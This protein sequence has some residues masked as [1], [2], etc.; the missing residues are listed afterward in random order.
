MEQVAGVFFYSTPVTHPTPLFEAVSRRTYWIAIA[1]LTLL[2]AGLTVLAG[3]YDFSQPEETIGPSV[4]NQSAIPTEILHS[5][6]GQVILLGVFQF[7]AANLVFW[8]GLWLWR[9]I[10]GR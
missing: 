5:P 9:K 4:R 1:P 10:T 2:M 8:G 6:I 7:L 3:I